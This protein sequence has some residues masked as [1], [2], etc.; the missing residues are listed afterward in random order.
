MD[1]CVLRKQGW[2]GE[3]QV[4]NTSRW[5][6]DF[7]QSGKPC[8]GVKSAALYEGGSWAAWEQVSCSEPGSLGPY[9][10]SGPVGHPSRIWGLGKN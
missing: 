8:R 5:S 4:D 3:K 6:P 7:N 1:V 2:A 9:E 10:A